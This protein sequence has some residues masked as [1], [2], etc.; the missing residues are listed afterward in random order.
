VNSLPGLQV[1]AEF[2]VRSFGS[3]RTASPIHDDSRSVAG[4]HRLSSRADRGPRRNPNHKEATQSPQVA[5]PT[6]VPRPV[7]PCTY[8][9]RL[10]AT[11]ADLGTRR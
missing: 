5:K 6:L 9:V 8:R 4:R 3:G 11:V 2:D 10:R 7:Q 1:R